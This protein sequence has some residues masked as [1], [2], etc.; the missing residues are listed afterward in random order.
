MTRSFIYTDAFRRSW[1][2]MGLSDESLSDLEDILLENPHDGDV[3]PGLSGARKMRVQLEG[4]GKR[5]GARVIYLDILV[6]EHTYMLFAYPKNVQENLT[7]SQ[8]KA[9]RKIGG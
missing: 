1:S 9:L 7:E 4:R 5:G 3:I 6:S 2:A 8:E